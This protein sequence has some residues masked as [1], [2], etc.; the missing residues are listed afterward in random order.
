MSKSEVIRATSHDAALPSCTGSLLGKLRPGESTLSAHLFTSAT[1]V[2]VGAE[3]PERFLFPAQ[4]RPKPAGWPRRPPLGASAL[5]SPG[6][7]PAYLL[8]T[9]RSNQLV[10]GLQRQSPT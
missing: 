3:N 1:R 5:S 4:P 7:L 8:G 10:V 6:A 9:P 2:L